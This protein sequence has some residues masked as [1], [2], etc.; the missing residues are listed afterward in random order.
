ML[1]ASQV[2]EIDENIQID[3]LWS[4]VIA[5]KIEDLNDPNCPNHNGAYDCTPFC[6]VCEGNQTYN[7]KEN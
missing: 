3:G 5:E 7:P 2:K 4:H 1:T 6:Q